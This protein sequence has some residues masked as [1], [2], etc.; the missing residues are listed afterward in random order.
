MNYSKEYIESV[1]DRIAEIIGNICYCRGYKIVIT[2][3]MDS[4]PIINYEVEELIPP[5]QIGAEIEEKE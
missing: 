5:V 3:E 1:T 2:Q 4:V